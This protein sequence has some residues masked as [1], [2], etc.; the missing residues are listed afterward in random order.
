MELSCAKT[1]TGGR[2][3]PAPAR[4]NRFHFGPARTARR[5]GRPRGCPP[6][7]QPSAVSSRA[8]VCRSPRTSA[9]EL[10]PESQLSRVACQVWPIT[11]RAAC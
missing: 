4:W 10:R 1:L 5:P 11:R 3:G 6:G 7:A 8:A 2:G 9:S